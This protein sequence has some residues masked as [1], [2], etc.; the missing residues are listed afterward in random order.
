[1]RWLYVIVI[2]WCLYLIGDL[3]KKYWLTD[4]S[5]EVKPLK[6]GVQDEVEK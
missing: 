3:L 4:V 1:M 2:V 6:A 5:L